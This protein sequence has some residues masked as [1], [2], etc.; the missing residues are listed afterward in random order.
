M[1]DKSNPLWAY[2]LPSA[3]FLMAPFDILSSLAMDVYLPII[4][5]MPTALNTSPAIVQLTLSV[6]MIVLG[7]GQVVFGPMSDRIG[8]RPIV[9][10][11]AFFFTVSSFALAMTSNGPLFVTLR[12]LQALGASAMLVATFATVRDVYANSP[13]SSVIYSLFGSML[14][15]VPAL[16]P[17][18]GAVIAMNCGWRA[19]FVMLGILGLLAFCHA[20]LRWHE[21]RPSR[22]SRQSPVFWSILGSSSFW[23]YTLGFSTAMGAFFVFFSTSPRVLIE[24]LG[25]SQI[26][27]S[28][29]FATVA[30]VMI[31]TTRFARFFVSRWGVEGSL[32]RGLFVILMG[33]CILTG[34]TLLTEP[35]IL[36]FV[37]PMW[38][39]AVGMVL[40]VSVTAN[41]ALH[42]FSN[43]AGTAVALYYSVQSLIVGIVGTIVIVTLPGD[44]AWPLIAYCLILVTV[45]LFVMAANRLMR[46][47]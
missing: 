44:S 26:I 29:I 25:L 34:C 8:R 14:A 5:E 12:V 27:F 39:I 28:A 11:G 40:V 22:Q 46:R 21:T 7:L 30:F 41:G 19:I 36:T 6:Y 32:I 35:S 23:I 18:L 16:G 47:S 15:F 45:T 4:P 2:S 37:L 20:L 13:E 42:D 33:A 10:G 43:A 31:I 3:L 17:I 24:R 38:L 9:L 1:S